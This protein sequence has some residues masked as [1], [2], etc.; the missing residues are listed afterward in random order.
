MR[1][2][3]QHSVTVYIHVQTLRDYIVSGFRLAFFWIFLAQCKSYISVKIY[4]A[5]EHVHRMGS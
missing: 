5:V 4:L 3:R 1:Y 2:V